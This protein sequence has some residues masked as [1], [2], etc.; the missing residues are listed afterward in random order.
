MYT[1]METQLENKKYIIVENVLSNRALNILKPYAQLLP[2][3]KSSY[4]IWPAKSTNNNTIAEC[5]TCDVLGK[6]R[7]EIINELYSNDKLP[8]YNKNWLRNCDIAIQKI[9]PGGS[10]PKHRDHC[11]F[12]LTVFLSTVT[13]GEFKWWDGETAYKIAPEINK[14]V[15]CCYDEYTIGAAHEVCEVIKD[16]RFTLQLF[17]FDKKSKASEENSVVWYMEEK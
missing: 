3:D 16:V 15:I 7:L 12:S 11:I 17:V 14:G 10:I 5:F 8:C 9:P 6:D 13:G 2:T 4:N 1:S